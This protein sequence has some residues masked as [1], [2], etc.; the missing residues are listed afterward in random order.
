MSRSLRIEAELS[1]RSQT[2]ITDVTDTALWVAAVRAAEGERNDAAFRDPFASMLAGERGKTIA[3]Y[4]PDSSSVSW[5]VVMRTSAIDRL[6]EEAIQQGVD[7]VVNLGAG[8][9]SRPFR[10]NLPPDLR[11]IEIDFPA[12]VNS[13]NRA[14]KGCTPRCKVERMGMNLLDRAARQAFMTA[15]D[16]ES[17]VGSGGHKT[18]L[19]AEGVIPYW[20]RDDVAA[21]AQDLG[22]TQSFHSWIL[23]F[24]NAGSRQTPKSWEKRLKAAPFLFQVPDWFK[25]F[26]QC[27]W[28]AQ[29]TIS[30]AEES[31]RL[32][33]PYPLTIPKGLLMRA[34]P[35]E[36]RGRILSASGAVLLEKSGK[37]SSSSS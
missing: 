22:S 16:S 17:R 26:E 9:D 24:D 5:G 27:G 14:L 28:H 23:D 10:M 13:K 3:R 34:L 2:M 6:I 29:R 31:A 1:V 30:S 8:M 32:H 36:V 20:S 25:F 21:V 37:R 33:R 19:I 4:F 35:S 18:L 7:T 15:V 11:W 12:L